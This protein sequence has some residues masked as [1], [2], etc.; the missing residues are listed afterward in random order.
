MATLTSVPPSH[1][2]QK[3]MNSRQTGGGK[4]LTNF[5]SRS[6]S[7]HLVAVRRRC[8]YAEALVRCGLASSAVVSSAARGGASGC[9][10]EGPTE[11]GGSGDDAG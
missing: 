11:G 5:S 6:S 7:M 8:S 3:Y 10:G 4:R 2:R 1:A 9:V